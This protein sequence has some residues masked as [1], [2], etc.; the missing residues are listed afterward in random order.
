MNTLKHVRAILALPFMVTVIVPALLAYVA[1]PARPGW[2]LPAPWNLAALLGGVLLVTV[3]LLL[4]VWT[5]MMFDR[6]G[7]GTLA[8]WDPTRRLVVHGVYRR[9]RNPMITGVFAI[10]LGEAVLLMSLAILLWFMV[11]VC[12]NAVYIPLVEERHLEQRFGDAYRA[13]K[14]YVPR[15][16]PRLHAWQPQKGGKDR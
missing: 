10:L 14:R 12:L 9:V 1:P 13:Y 6:I 3:G 15:W 5:T 4:L 11:F 16:I 8:P 2:S 7:D